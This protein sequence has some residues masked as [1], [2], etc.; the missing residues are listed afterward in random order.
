MIYLILYWEFLKIGLFAI[1][2]GLVTIPFIFHLLEV[3]GWLS[4]DEFASIIGI[5][6]TLPGAMGVNLSIF[7]GYS[8]AGILGGVISALGLITGPVIVILALADFL[9]KYN[10]HPIFR[11]VLSGI[12][13][14]VIAMI[15][16]ATL[17]VAKVSIVDLRSLIICGIFFAIMLLKNRTPIIYIALGAIT[18]VVLGL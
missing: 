2:G 11:N 13:P 10:N 5:N 4:A 12:R 6:Q 7:V 16:L 1:G 8:A 9:K 17:S 18:G 14:A 15:L 3:Y